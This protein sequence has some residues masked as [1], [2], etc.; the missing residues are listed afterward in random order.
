MSQLSAHYYHSQIIKKHNKVL[1]PSL[2]EGHQH[3]AHN[4][5]RLLI[6]AP[7]QSRKNHIANNLNITLLYDSQDTATEK[8]RTCHW[9]SL[10]SAGAVPASVVVLDNRRNDSGGNNSSGKRRTP[11]LT[12]SQF[13]SPANASLLQKPN[14]A[15]YIRSSTR[16][17]TIRLNHTHHLWS[18]MMPLYTLI[19][20]LRRIS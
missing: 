4:K 14:R 2:Q 1:V 5:T 15:D 19:L 8:T 7:L 20:C 11:N 18:N 6:Y 16:K 17:Q 13:A 9:G 3:L 12:V 10:F